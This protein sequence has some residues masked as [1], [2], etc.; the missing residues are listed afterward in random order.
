MK[1]IL[2]ITLLIVFLLIYFGIKKYQTT[3]HNNI[4]KESLFLPKS[5][6]TFLLKIEN[7]KY[8]IEVSEHV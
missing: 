2:I 7:G 8:Y 3:H 5:P 1:F 4:K 6:D